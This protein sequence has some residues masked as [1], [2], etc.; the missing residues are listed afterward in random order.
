MKMQHIVVAKQWTEQFNYRFPYFNSVQI[1]F[2]CYLFAIDLSML[3]GVNE[4]G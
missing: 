4:L 2:G 3:I 1:S